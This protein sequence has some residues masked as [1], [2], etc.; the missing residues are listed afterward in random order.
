MVS[1]RKFSIYNDGGSYAVT[2][3]YAG[4]APF[5][6]DILGDWREE[7]I[8]ET[9][10]RSQLR[11]YS[12]VNTAST[13]IYALMQN[14]AYRIDV[15]T[16][17]YLCSKYPD[18]YLGTGMS[19]PAKP[20]ITFPVANGTYKLI[21][22]HSGKAVDVANCGT[23]DGVN[24]QQWTDLGNTCQQWIVSNDGNGAYTLKN[25][26]SSKVLD[27]NACGTANKTNVQLWTGLGNNC[28]KWTLIA[29]GGGY[30]QVKNVNSGKCLDVV[31]ALTTDGANIQQ[32]TC[33]GADCQKFL[34]TTQL[35]SA[36]LDVEE[37][38]Q[39]SSVIGSGLNISPNPVDGSTTQLSM[40]L[41]EASEVNVVVVDYFG[42]VVFRQNLGERE[43][44]AI[45]ES[46]DLS[47]L[48]KGVYIVTVQTNL[49]AKSTK[50][51][52]L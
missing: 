6:G 39:E 21:A 33:N 45:T 5:I 12:T 31:N 9:S 14:P 29:D 2:C 7:V 10:D 3:P 24:V 46:L 26:N 1:D 36:T 22:K 27:V 8:L 47:S 41:Q 43:A 19:T 15:C 30:Y 37:Y 16:K 44:G 49:G 13:R 17:G 35:K 52:R 34:F 38:I 51:I 32:Y 48:P 42:K 23:A 28:Q 25:V 4:R 11:I 18:Y 20:N 50:L 40:E